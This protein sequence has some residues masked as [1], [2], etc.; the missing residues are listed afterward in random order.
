M[1][2]PLLPQHV[3]ISVMLVIQM[4]PYTYMYTWDWVWSPS[5][6]TKRASAI[7]L[8]V[9]KRT[10]AENR[11]VHMGSASFRDGCKGGWGQGDEET[12]HRHPQKL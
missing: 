2:I 6:I 10:R 7:T 3:V 12:I 5:M 9:E 1:V 4:H 8:T 11:K